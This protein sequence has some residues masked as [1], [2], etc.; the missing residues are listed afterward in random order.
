M[1]VSPLIVA[2]IL[3]VGLP[4]GARAQTPAD[5]VGCDRAI[6]T[7]ATGDTAAA[8]RAYATITRCGDRGVQAV[9]MALRNTKNGASPPLADLTRSAGLLRSDRIFDE[10]AFLAAATRA[11]AEAR[12]AGLTV[13]ARQ[14]DFQRAAGLTPDG[15]CAEAGDSTGEQ[16]TGALPPDRVQ[17]GYALLATLANDRS[18]PTPLRAAA[19]CLSNQLQHPAPPDVR[20]DEIAIEAG[21]GRTVRIH[22]TAPDLATIDLRETAGGEST[23]VTVP[24]GET[25]E[26]ATSTD[27]TVEFSLQGKRIWIRPAAKPGCS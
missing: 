10:A 15:R 25:R 21:C 7:V 18:G 13:V 2:G 9:V 26:F 8:A 20:P 22:N 3:A 1:R 17:R 27:G 16:P 14:L 4:T 23:S 5:T 19:R 24:P 6:S 11:S 12:I